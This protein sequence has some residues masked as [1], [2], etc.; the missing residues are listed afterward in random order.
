MGNVYK[1]TKL[2][3]LDGKIAEIGSPSELLSRSEGR[4]ARLVEEKKDKEEAGAGAAPTDSTAIAVEQVELQQVLEHIETSTSNITAPLESPTVEKI[5]HAR[6][7]STISEMLN[8]TRMSIR[9]H[10]Q[11]SLRSRRTID[12]ASK[13]HSVGEKQLIQKEGVET[14]RVN[15]H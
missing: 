8:E 11:T 12:T 1:Q 10:R 6:K 13:E 3:N 4:F 14:G 15:V 7:M 9:K 2:A 5:E